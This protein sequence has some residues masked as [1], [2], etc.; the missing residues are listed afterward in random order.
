[1]AAACGRTERIDS[2]PWTSFGSSPTQVAGV[3][4]NLH[5]PM[6]CPIYP[7]DATNAAKPANPFPAQISGLCAVDDGGSVYGIV[8][9]DPTT[10][11]L[12]VV[13]GNRELGVFVA[14]APD[15]PFSPDH[16]YF[17][18][19]PTLHAWADGPCCLTPPPPDV[20]GFQTVAA[21]QTGLLVSFGQFG[22]EPLTLSF[23]FDLDAMFGAGGTYRQAFNVNAIPFDGG[24]PAG[25]DAGT[26][27][28]N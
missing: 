22:A 7:P 19:Q 21:D 27:G 12:A 28:R 3:Q 11:Q 18:G 13:P 23:Y 14:F 20:R 2:A 1:L 16:L 26:D 5:A 4:S 6:G 17:N 15:W 10:A 25:A 9:L 8:T 24:A